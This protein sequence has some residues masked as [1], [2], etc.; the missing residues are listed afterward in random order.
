MAISGPRTAMAF[1]MR[2]TRF[3]FPGIIL[4]LY[5]SKS[6]GC[7]VMS[8]ELPNAACASCARGSACEPVVTII[9]SLGFTWSISS[10]GTKVSGSMGAMPAFFAASR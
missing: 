2:I 4:A 1:I 3:S 6:S 8:R 9:S 7:R 5:R 10:A